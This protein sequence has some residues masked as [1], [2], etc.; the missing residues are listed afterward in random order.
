[1]EA[2]GTISLIPN[3][4]FEGSSVEV[5]GIADNSSLKIYYLLQVSIKC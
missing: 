3:I 1:M 2:L 5:D 4:S